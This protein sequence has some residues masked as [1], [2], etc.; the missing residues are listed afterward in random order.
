[1]ATLVLTEPFIEITNKI[2]GFIGD[3]LC[4][5]YVHNKLSTVTF[6]WYEKILNL[7]TSQKSVKSIDPS[8][9]LYKVNI[10]TETA[11]HHIDMI[12]NI[13]N[14][15]Y[16]TIQ[17]DDKFIFL[18]C[19]HIDSLIAFL[20]ENFNS[21]NKY[22]FIPVVFGSEVNKIGHFSM[23]VFDIMTNKVYFA[24]PNGKT[25][26][27]D[28]IMIKHCIIDIDFF[29]EYT[30]DM[31][32]NCEQLIEKIFIFYINQLNSKF[33]TKYTFISRTTWNP[34]KYHLN[35][36][37]STSQIGNGHCVIT[38]TLIANYLSTT[39]SD[40]KELYIKFDNMTENEILQLI[41]SYSVGIYECIIQLNI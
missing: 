39:N 35:K 29:S 3:G 26:F 30:N 16:T 34:N 4:D 15:F 40:I 20:A 24:D 14:M 21:N 11:D 28:D 8:Y 32:I 1:M 5:S 31:Y 37:I 27:F 22:V 17:A 33:D 19:L 36:S 7:I 38:S 2:M 23:L 6:D 18:H 10:F 25:H 41:N 12:S 13:G 9:S